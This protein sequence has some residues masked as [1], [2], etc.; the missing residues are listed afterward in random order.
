[1]N[2]PHDLTTTEAIHKL[3]LRNTDKWI[4]MSWLMSTCQQYNFQC[5]Q[6]HES[7]CQLSLLP[8]AKYEHLSV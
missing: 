2:I 3:T 6:L 1:M 7:N 5:I 4:P 8:T